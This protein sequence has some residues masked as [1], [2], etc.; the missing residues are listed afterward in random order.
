MS[1]VLNGYV[2]PSLSVTNCVKFETSIRLFLNTV[3]LL[4]LSYIPTNEMFS[5]WFVSNV[6]LTFSLLRSP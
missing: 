2:V 6:A 5:A 3:L 1:F 4:P